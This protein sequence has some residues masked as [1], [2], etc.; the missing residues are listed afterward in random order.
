[1]TSKIQVRRQFEANDNN[2]VINTNYVGCTIAYTVKNTPIT[3]AGV[4]KTFY[5]IMDFDIPNYATSASF[6]KV[7]SSGITGPVNITVTLSSGF[8]LISLPA[9]GIVMPPNSSISIH[10][11]FNRLISTG[12]ISGFV[13]NVNYSINVSSS[14]TVETYGVNNSLTINLQSAGTPAI[15]PNQSYA[16]GPGLGSPTA[17][18]LQT[19]TIFAVAA[20]GSNL[21]HGGGAFNLTLSGAGTTTRAIVDNNNGSYTATYSVSAA[22]AWTI[23]VTNASGASIRDFPISL[24]VT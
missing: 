16:A 14:T 11:K 10:V 22:G 3:G 17:N 20:N 15:D 19:F 2:Q 4:N 13:R 5:W 9:S 23:N 24:T 12:V 21:T 8:M 1:M 7:V 18:T 6:V